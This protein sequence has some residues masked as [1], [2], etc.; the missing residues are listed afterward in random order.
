MK[1]AA[2][3]ILYNLAVWAFVLAVAFPLLWM[4]STALK[5]NDETFAVPPTLIPVH[6][7]LDQFRRLLT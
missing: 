7:T 2:G 6:P 5:P 1:R 3:F 4:V